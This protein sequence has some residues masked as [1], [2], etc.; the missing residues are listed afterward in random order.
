M[1]EGAT[2]V[3]QAQQ[4][5]AEAR[6]QLEESSTRATALQSRISELEAA[7]EATGKAVGEVNAEK[8]TTLTQIEKLEK[9][10]RES[11]LKIQEL[12]AV[13]TATPKELEELRAQLSD[14]DGKLTALR[15]SNTELQQ[16]M[17][18]RKLEVEIWKRQFKFLTKAER[19]PEQRQ[20]M[21]S[22]KK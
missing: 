20:A 1:E 14:R 21:L 3:A 5:A 4:M 16:A 13:P 2:I 22:G 12:K 7:N 10:A 8:L 11:N 18:S 19:L 6:G 17:E 15:G 9:E